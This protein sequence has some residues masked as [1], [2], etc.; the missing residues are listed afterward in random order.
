MKAEERNERQEEA[1][2]QMVEWYNDSDCEW[3]GPRAAFDFS[4]PI[5]VF[6]QEPQ[7][8]LIVGNK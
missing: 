3:R 7:V 6:P 2:R 5:V 1:H 8:Q 4:K